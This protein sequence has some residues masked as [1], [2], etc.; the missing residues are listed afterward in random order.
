MRDE[1]LDRYHQE[2]VALQ[3]S[4][5]DKPVADEIQPLLFDL[6]K[7]DKVDAVKAFLPEFNRLNTTVREEL[8]KL[9]AIAGS[10]AMLHLIAPLKECGQP[11]FPKDLIICSIRGENMETFRYLL[12][13]SRS[14]TPAHYSRLYVSYSTVLGQVL[15][16]DSEEMYEEW[17]KYVD[18]EIK[19][20]SGQSGWPTEA[21]YIASSVISA[22]AGNPRREQVLLLLW[23]KVDLYKSC[24]VTYLGDALVN[25]ASTT[26]S[27]KLAKFL[28]DCGAKVDHR[29]S[30]KYRTPLHHAA[31]RT[32]AEAAEM[33]KFL[34]FCGADPDADP[35]ACD[36]FRD[37]RQYL[38]I[39]DEKGAKGISKWLGMSW[40]DLVTKA[41]EERQRIGD[42]TKTYLGAPG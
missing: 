35:L 16:S 20:G 3:V 2:Q 7:A 42:E 22:T 14:C 31:R 41:K 24:G 1:H 25:V 21:R 26:C 10:P 5:L 9:A 8:Q 28:I 6:V 40:D 34:L 36:S 23:E 27:V 37:R 11:K 17:E 18:I 15:M 12:S 4:A 29:R 39:Q 13:E 33:M 30:S 38:R 32:T 19:A